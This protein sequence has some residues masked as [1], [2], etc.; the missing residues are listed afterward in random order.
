LGHHNLVDWFSS[1]NTSTFFPTPLG[2]VNNRAEAR[3]LLSMAFNK[4]LVM[5]CPTT[6]LNFSDIYA[7]CHKL[8]HRI[9]IRKRTKTP[10]R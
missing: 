8:F 3:W 6:S 10:S 1:Q 9:F 5:F 4:V 2:P 7:I